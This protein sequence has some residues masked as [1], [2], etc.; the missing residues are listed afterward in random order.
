VAASKDNQTSKKDWTSIIPPWLPVFITCATLI[1]TFWLHSQ[2][3]RT[4]AHDKLLEHR[5]EALFSA[6]K[7]IDAVYSNEPW[8]DRSPAHPL[9]VDVQQARDADNEM[10]IYCQYPETLSAFRKALGL[11]NPQKDKVSSHPSLDGFNEFRMQVARELDLPQP[12]GVDPNYVWISN[13]DGA[14]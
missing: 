3:Q 7:V 10:R 11:W 13:L 4:A 6:L 2:D 8:N 14:K 1:A 5:R 9:P 12:I